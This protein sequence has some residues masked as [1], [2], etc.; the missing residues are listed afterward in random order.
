[1]TTATKAA[2]TPSAPATAPSKRVF[3]FSAGPAMLP[4]DVIL[5]ARDDLWDI[6]GTGIGIMEHSHRGKAFDRVIEEAVADCR[7]VANISDD[8]EILF[9]QGGATLQFAMIPMSFLAPGKTADYIDTGEWSHKA[10]KEARLFGNVNVAF[11]GTKTNYDH[12][13]AASEINLSSNAAYLHYTSNN[14]IYGTQFKS[15]PKSN[16]P[17]IVD[18]SSDIFSRPIDVSA[19][20]MIYAGAQKNLGPSG[21]VLVLIRKDFLAHAKSDLPSMLN[22]PQ[23]AEKGSRLNTPPTFGIYFMGQVFKWILRNGGLQG[24]ARRNEEK[25]RLVYD[26][27]DHS[28]GFYTCVP[29]ADSR[30]L[31]NITF[32]LPN[33]ELDAAFC[34]EA[35][36]RDLA[37]LRGYRSVGGIRASCY[38]AMPREGCER[39]AE[40]MREF[41]QKH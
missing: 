4:E 7:K 34:A 17:L 38:N 2:P 28:D 13:P 40:F 3:N 6:F 9:L 25:A 39:L 15:P 30:S 27:V 20:A 21:V 23:M 24:M 29:R 5:Q 32:R 35:A 31:M 41:A 33:E 14:T 16:A 26:A 1:M 12:V 22:Y 18:A 36:K 11:D 10:I 19:H 37:G 8:Y